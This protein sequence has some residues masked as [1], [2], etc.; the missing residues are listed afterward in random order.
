VAGNVVEIVVK[1]RDQSGAGF[2][3][4]QKRAEGL[5]SKLGEVGK[6]AGGF[7]AAHVISKGFEAF[8]GFV[9]GSVKASSDLGESVNAVQKVFGASSRTIL[10]WGK[11]SANSY[12]LSQRAFNELATP[13]GAGLK[14]AGLSLQDTSKWTVD[15]TKRASDMASVFNTSVPDALGAIQAGLRGEADPLERFGVGLSAAKVAAE[16]MA[17]TGKKS[18]SALTAQELVT[19]RLNLIMKQTASTQG[20]FQQTSTGL[21]N[22]QRIASAKT[23]ELQA[24]I[25]DKLKPVV[26]AVTQA[27]LKLVGV[28]ADKLVPAFSAFAGWVGRNAGLVKVLGVA[29]GGALVAAFVAWAASAA[30]AAVATIAATAP[31]LLIGA[32]IGLLVLGLVKAWKHSETFRAVVT[33][34]FKSA[35]TVVLSMARLMLAAVLGFVGGVLTVMGKMPGPLG[36]PFRKAA[37]VVNRFKTSALASLDAAQRKVNEFGAAVNNLPNKKYVDIITRFHTLGIKPSTTAGLA[38]GGIAGAAAGGI[39]SNLVRVGERGDE[40]VR[41]PVGSRVYPHGSA[42]SG[43]AG[44]G[45]GPP[46]VVLQVRPGG[47]GLDRL[48]VEWLRAAVQVRGGNVQ[49]VLGR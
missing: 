30:A 16:A 32:A 38:H 21:A 35:A 27:K 43:A 39:R 37:E 34:V 23:E 24:K 11:S 26:L 14:N 42:P 46:P 36:A 25:G 31:V 17:E 47:S 4:A 19:A 22:A 9:S 13:L 33:A 28:V 6:V 1:S 15:L 41:L 44:A 18:A 29:V 3:S 45:W 10:D 8:K 40:L 20:D 7:L 2:A 5:G 49:T 48:F 12:G